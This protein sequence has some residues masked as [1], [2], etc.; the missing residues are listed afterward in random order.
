MAAI[1]STLQYVHSYNQSSMV[2]CQKGPTRHAY[3]WQI[4]PFWQDT[5]AISLL[6]QLMAVSSTVSQ[7]TNLQHIVEILSLDC[8]NV[9]EFFLF[10]VILITTP[11]LLLVT[12]TYM[13]MLVGVASLTG[14]ALLMIVVPINALCFSTYAKRKMVRSHI[15]AQRSIFIVCN[16]FI[17]L[18][19]A[20]KVSCNENVSELD[21][22][23]FCRY[24]YNCK[25]REFGPGEYSFTFSANYV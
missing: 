22:L 24:S 23:C 8:E 3:A 11:L 19:K 2:S 17:H 7:R 13:W 12:L 1:S 15:I 10:V 18:I 16:S 14:P 20:S 6:F 9:Q 25:I 5:L 4:G 21:S